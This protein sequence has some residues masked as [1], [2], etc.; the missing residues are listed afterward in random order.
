MND[1]SAH[2][3]SSLRPPHTCKSTIQCSFCS[4]FGLHPLLWK[5]SDFF[6]FL[7][8]M[9]KML[10]IHLLVADFV[11]PLFT[12]NIFFCCR[13]QN[14]KQMLHTEKSKQLAQMLKY[15]LMYA[16]VCC[17]CWLCV[18]IVLFDVTHWPH[19]GLS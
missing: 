7:C 18:F 14:G 17:H 3:K 6:F 8:K 5:V 12:E 15:M 4:V 9:L 11:H 2:F 10:N 16:K 19:E 13:K 1:V